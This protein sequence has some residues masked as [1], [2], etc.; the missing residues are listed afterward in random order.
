MEWGGRSRGATE[1]EGE[2]VP[3]GGAPGVTTTC[4]RGRGRQVFSLPVP[5]P[6]RLLPVLLV[7]GAAVGGLPG[8]PGSPFSRRQV[9]KECCVVLPGGAG[10]AVAQ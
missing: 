8:V 5:A 9:H 1:W 4:G 7:L 6:L 10:E 3:G 2:G